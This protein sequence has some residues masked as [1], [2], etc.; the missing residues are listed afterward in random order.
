[1]ALGYRICTW[2]DG[3]WHDGD[4]AVLRAADHGAWQG[5]MVFDGARA[6]D[7][8]TPDLDRHCARILRSA[9]AMGM[10]PP[11]SAAEIEAIVRDGIRRY[12]P[13]AELYLRPMMWSRA[14]SPAYV[15]PLPESTAF[16]VCIEDIPMGR[17]GGANALT[18]SPYRR[19]RPDM[20]VTEAK[21][22]SLYAN[23]GRIVAEAR[24][25]GFHNAL[26]LDWEDHVAETAMTNVFLVRDGVVFTPV[27]NGMFLAGITRARVIELL[28]ADGVEVVE[29]RLTVA[30]F[31]AADEIFTTGNANKVMPVTRFETRDLPSTE[32]A[33][34]ARALYWDFAHQTRAAA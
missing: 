26:S 32:M 31:E 25:R 4:V 24:R 12:P 10:I 8:V 33:R 30:D 11:V 17:P 6:F 5:T 19:P 2:V 34:R 22:G 21:A 9:E 29:T 23:N 18:V 15:D 28:R 1:M 14:C 27:P 20:A 16:V 3:R 13:G 7:G